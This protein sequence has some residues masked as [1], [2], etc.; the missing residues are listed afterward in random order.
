MAAELFTAH[1]G[2]AGDSDFA[3]ARPRARDHMEGDVGKLLLGVRGD[4]CVIAAS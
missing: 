1:A 3:D 2:V 4:V